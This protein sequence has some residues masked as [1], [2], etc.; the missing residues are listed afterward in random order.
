M[1]KRVAAAMA[2]AVLAACGP[3]T[4]PSANTPSAAPAAFLPRA[5][6][7]GDPEREQAQISPDG[8]WLSYLDRREG[9]RTLTAALVADR[10]DTRVIAEGASDYFWSAD[11]AFIVYRVGSGWRT[12]DLL[13]TGEDHMLVSEP[14]AQPFPVSAARPAQALFELGADLYEIDIR[15][16]AR[17]PVF[18]NRYGY[19][20]FL[21]DA[22][23]R[24]VVGVKRLPSGDL[25]ITGLAGAAR[26]LLLIPAADA[27]QTRVLTGAPNGANFLLISTFGRKHAA[28]MRVDLTTGAM[29]AVAQDDQADI[30]AVWRTPSTGEVE[31]YAA[32]SFE[33]RWTPLNQ[34]AGADMALLKQNLKAFEILSRSAD[35]KIWI[36]REQTPSLA[37]RVWLYDRAAKK[38]ERLFSEHPPLEGVSFATPKPVNIAVSKSENHDALLY[39][40]GALV[41]LLRDANAPAFGA[42]DPVAQY[43]VN[44]GFSVLDAR[45]GA[46]ADISHW[47][48]SQHLAAAGKNIALIGERTAL[49]ALPLAGNFGCAALV[50]APPYPEKLPAATGERILL[51]RLGIKPGDEKPSYPAQVYFP[52]ETQ[53]FARPE[54]RVAYYALTSAF[55]AP[56]IGADAA[57]IGGD[58]QGSSL[59]ILA[60]QTLFPTLKAAMAPRESEAGA[61]P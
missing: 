33:P 40:G 58:L 42:F 31:A 20:D 32:S 57:P 43:F 60:G 10:V 25:E 9:K 23:N 14:G 28:L 41:V 56:C 46:I 4:A 49:N 11:G 8:K 44:L 39:P 18:R 24:P 22:Q 1:L 51:A 45:G 29:N 17:T 12:R 38:I 16:G 50:D 21:F 30:T 15:T 47:A 13:R 2:L 61:P 5:A 27:A 35:N 54:N 48:V 26:K 3:A 6:L 53:P 52:D 36:V 34:I 19:S 55:I 7:F 37:P 59:E